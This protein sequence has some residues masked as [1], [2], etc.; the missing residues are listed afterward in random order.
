MLRSR[1]SSRFQ[2]FNIPQRIGNGT[3]RGFSVVTS[4]W[5]D[6]R[7]YMGIDPVVVSG[8]LS[9]EKCFQEVKEYIISHF[10]R[11]FG[12]TILGVLWNSKICSIG[13][14]LESNQLTPMW[15]QYVGSTPKGSMSQGLRLISS[16][17][18]TSFSRLLGPFN[19]GPV[20][21]PHLQ[22]LYLFWIESESNYPL[23]W[24]LRFRFSSTLRSG[25]HFHQVQFVLVS[26][27]MHTPV[28]RVSQ[29]HHAFF[30]NPSCLNGLSRNLRSHFMQ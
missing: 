28:R 30:F 18:C 19:R 1:I 2:E 14:E 17:Y 6:E 25:H 27:S 8:H 29:R 21:G 12:V 13:L 10:S 7:G 16:T 4:S 23:A 26:I 3:P 15:I 24:Y 9:M 20:L 5:A 22:S 11:Y